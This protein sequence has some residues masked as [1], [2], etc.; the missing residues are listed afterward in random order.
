MTPN[1]PWARKRFCFLLAACFL[2]FSPLPLYPRE[3]PAI[4]QAAA[5]AAEGNTAQAREVLGKAYRKNGA[6]KILALAY[7]QTLADG[8]EA[9]KIFSRIAFDSTN[10]DSLR[11]RAFLRLGEAALQRQ[12]TMEA[13]SFISSACGLGRQPEARIL[14]GRALLDAGLHDSAVTCLLPLLKTGTDSLKPAA[15]FYIGR[16]F[17]KERRFKEALRFLTDIFDTDQHSS[18]KPFILMSMYECA[19]QLGEREESARLRKL[20]NNDYLSITRQTDFSHLDTLRMTLESDVSK[21]P[22]ARIQTEGGP[23]NA[24][25]DTGMPENDTFTEED[26][27][28]SAETSLNT[29]PAETLFTLQVGAFGSRSNADKLQKQ[30]SADFPKVFISQITINNAAL[31]RVGVGVFSS[32]QE[33]TNFGQKRLQG[34]GLRFRIVGWDSRSWEPKR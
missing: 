8:Q 20:I 11:S 13:I 33:A 28:G 2:F 1:K 27:P 31:C 26:T 24:P 7:A 15:G 12:Q 3:N 30:L 25:A 6:D 23:H 17:I 19:L 21:G 5:L 18:F 16:A 9:I 29:S 22:A 34:H 4:A 32:R 10:A 14:L